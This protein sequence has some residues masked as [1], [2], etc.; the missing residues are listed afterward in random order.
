MHKMHTNK[1]WTIL[2]KIDTREQAVLAIERDAMAFFFVL[3]GIY[4]A[5]IIL[6]ENKWIFTGE[7]LFITVNIMLFWAAIIWLRRF[8]SR[9][10]AILILAIDLFNITISLQAH[11]GVTFKTMVQ[12]IVLWCSV[13]VIEATFKLH[14]RFRTY[15]A[16]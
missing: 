15:K 6:W 2:S 8:K 11:E 4:T 12:L 1:Q 13:R 5:D 14:G 16:N 7:T 3:A 10:A 9:V